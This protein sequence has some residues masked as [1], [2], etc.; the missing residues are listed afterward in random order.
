MKRRSL[1]QQV[2]LYGSLLVGVFFSCVPLFWLIRSSLMTLTELYIYPPLFWP[3]TN[4]WQNYFDAMTVVNFPLFI[5]NTITILIPVM[6]GT[7]ITSALAAY[8]FA[9]IRFPYKNIW[10]ALVISSLLLALRRHNDSHL[11]GVGT[12]RCDQHFLPVVGTCM[13]WR[14]RLQYFSVTAV[15]F[16]YS[17]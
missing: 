10:F 16:E 14:G 15:F 17:Q 13:V 8:G 3:Q 11:Y 7:L 4:R 1:V 5:L 6:F 12:F 9:R 2:G